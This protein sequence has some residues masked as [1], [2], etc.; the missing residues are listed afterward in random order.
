MKRV[1]KHFAQELAIL[2]IKKW[3][4]SFAGL[5]LLTCFVPMQP[6][7]AFIEKFKS[8]PADN[9][10]GRFD[11]AVND[12]ESDHWKMIPDIE[13]WIEEDVRGNVVN[14]RYHEGDNEH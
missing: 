4:K 5:G 1:D 2:E 7:D 9:L 6:M 13:V 12:K 3:I 8:S 10:S 14:G 11:D